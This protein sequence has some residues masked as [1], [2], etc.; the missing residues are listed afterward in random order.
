MTRTAEQ[1]AQET[2]GGMI[3]QL[4]VQI[5]MLR[6]QVEKLQEQVTEWKE[7]NNGLD[8]DPGESC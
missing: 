7:K 4:L 6:A 1:I 8:V 2:I 3:Y 5:S